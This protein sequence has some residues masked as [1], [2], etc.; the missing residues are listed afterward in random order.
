M[1]NYKIKRKISN[2]NYIPLSD[3]VEFLLDQQE[4][5]GHGD[6]EGLIVWYDSIV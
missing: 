6:Q 3:K 5:Q 4:L 2:P 1:S